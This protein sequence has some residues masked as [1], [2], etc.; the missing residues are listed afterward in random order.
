MAK[1]CNITVYFTDGN[2]EEYYGGL[3]ADEKLLRIYPA[4]GGETI[5]IPMVSIQKYITRN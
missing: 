1:L 4:D 5:N 2:I 3:H